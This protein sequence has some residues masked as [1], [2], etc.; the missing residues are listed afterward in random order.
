MPDT[1]VADIF[2]WVGALV[3]GIVAGLGLKTG[4]KDKKTAPAPEPQFAGIS[5]GLID[6]SVQQTIASDT[7]R[8]ADELV[9]I[10]RMIEKQVE[11]AEERREEAERDKIKD[12]LDKADADRQALMKVIEDMR[13]EIGPYTTARRL[14]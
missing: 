1:S 13:R 2:T 8:T 10:R 3:G 11:L 9:T 6:A 5:M 7:K 12:R 4:D 14:E